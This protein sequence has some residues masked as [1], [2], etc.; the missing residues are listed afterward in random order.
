M[1][2]TRRICVLAAAFAGLA[3][4]AA[5]PAHAAEVIVVDGD[6]PHRVHDP[7]VPSRARSPGPGSRVAVALATGAPTRPR[8]AYGAG[9][10]AP[11][12]AS[13]AT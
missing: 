2:G 6:T 3:A 8:A 4:G 7:A 10:V 13:S 11:G 1:S 9:C 12:G 5:G